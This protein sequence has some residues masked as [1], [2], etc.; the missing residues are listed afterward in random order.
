MSSRVVSYGSGRLMGNA[1]RVHPNVTLELG[2]YVSIE[3]SSVFG[4]RRVHSRPRVEGNRNNG[5]LNS[6]WQSR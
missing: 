4:R 1:H 3:L 5:G 6:G 2:S